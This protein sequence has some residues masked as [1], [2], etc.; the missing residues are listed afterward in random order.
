MKLKSNENFEMLRFS[1]NRFEKIT[2]EIQYKGEPVA[3]INQD[4][5]KGN[6]EVEI[7]SDVNGLNQ[8]LPLS[9]FIDSLIFARSLLIDE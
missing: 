2:I 1:D 3:Q 6:L 8:S 7:M 9:A 5:G 4:K